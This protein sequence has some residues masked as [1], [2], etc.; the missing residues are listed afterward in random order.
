MRILFFILAINGCKVANPVVSEPEF[1]TFPQSHGAHDWQTLEGHSKKTFL[2]S[3]VH[4]KE[5][6]IHYGIVHRSL[7]NS[8]GCTKEQRE[9]LKPKL[10]EAITKAVHIWLEPVKETQESLKDF[11][12]KIMDK[13]KKVKQTIVDAFNFHYLKPK[14]KRLSLGKGIGGKS[15]YHQISNLD[16]TKY[17]EKDRPHLSVVF[18]CEEG[19][20]YMLPLN[21]E[22]H[23]FEIPTKSRKYIKATIPDTNYSFTT[24]LHEIGHTFGLADTYTEYTRRGRDH[25]TD[26]GIHHRT[27]GT[28]PI[29]VMGPSYLL[30]YPSYDDVKITEDDA[31]GIRWLY[32]YLHVNKLS[33]NTCPA[34]YIAEHYSYDIAYRHSNTTIKGVEKHSVACTPKYPLIFAIRTRNYST[35]RAIIN[36]PLYTKVNDRDEDGNTALHYAV[37]SS[38]LGFVEALLNN[39][40][41]TID[42]NI[43]NNK[44]VTAHEAARNGKRQEIINLLDNH[45]S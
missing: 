3:H 9:L 4:K 36:N 24:L 18:Y 20:S 15:G 43:T 37:V 42:L 10:T 1:M 27:V 7:F 16:L 28:Q 6:K 11:T 31:Q 19:R 39:F 17:E 41:S 34:D 12:V 5:W 2:T 22:I 44:G 26:Q 45:N 35:A 29:A 32:I 25:M 13:E 23:M 30:N 21:N 40:K 14:R 38:P 8:R 33:L